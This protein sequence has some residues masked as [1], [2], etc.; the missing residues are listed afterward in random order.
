MGNWKTAGRR[1]TIDSIRLQKATRFSSSKSI[2]A[3]AL[4]IDD[5]SPLCPPWIIYR[6][7]TEGFRP[8]RG[9]PK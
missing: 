5:P 7:L 4:E 9:R 1:S 6:F 2:A 8:I 3:G